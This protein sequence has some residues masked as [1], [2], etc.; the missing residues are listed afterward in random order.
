MFVTMFIGVLD[1]LSGRMRYCNAGHDVPI[2][3][4]SGIGMLPCDSNIPVGVMQDWVYT[5]QET[6]IDPLTTIFL[7]TDGLTEAEDI[8]HAQFQEKRIIDVIQQ[9]PNEPQQIILAMTQA[10]HQFVGNA[11]QSD[12]LT[13]LALQYKRQQPHVRY[14][15]SLTLPNDVQTIQLLNEFVDNVCE[16]AGF[17]ISECMRMNLAI[18]E[19]VVNVMN[20]AYPKG[21]KGMVNIDATINDKGLKFVISDNGTPF[22]PTAKEEVDTTL[23]A[24]ERGIGGLGI[25][26]IRQIMDSINYEHIDGRNVLTLLKRI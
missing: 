6:T 15:R 5:L 24:E 18:E 3:I 8:N 21:V 16:A 19:A 17:D 23:S 26:L 22:D 20:Y 4:G 25:H 7:Y 1:L 10:V 12:D 9:A 2:L 13:M 14:Q 11:E